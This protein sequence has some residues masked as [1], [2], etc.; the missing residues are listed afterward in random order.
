MPLF[1]EILKE[2]VM[3][4]KRLFLTFLVAMNALLLVLLLG[5][6]APLPAA[7]AQAGRGG[8]GYVCA[9]SRI[10]GR[11]YEVLHMIDLSTRQLHTFF[12]DKNKI[13]SSPAP[14]ELDKDF[15]K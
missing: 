12:P 10:G 8:G 4:T 2:K 3:K 15:G 13:I 9:T 5:Q 11:T 6:A 1:F 14:R 7:M